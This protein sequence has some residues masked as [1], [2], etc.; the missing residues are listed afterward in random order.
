[1]A[2]HLEAVWVALFTQ[3]VVDVAAAYVATVLFAISINVVDCEKFIR[4]LT[5]ARTFWVVVGV[6]I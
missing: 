4:A 6:M 2:K 3:G 1:M 5:T